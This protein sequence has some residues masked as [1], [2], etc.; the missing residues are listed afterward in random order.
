MSITLSPTTT[1]ERPSAIIIPFPVRKPPVTAV[2]VTNE[3][4][5]HTRLVN[6]LASLNKAL[7]DQKAAVANFRE[8]LGTLAV[9]VQGMKGSLVTFQDSL[10]KVQ[11]GVTTINESAT[12]TVDILKDY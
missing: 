4:D 9:T 8:T 6:A 5:P 7:A 2:A 10:T 3:I 11:S 12:K 1:D